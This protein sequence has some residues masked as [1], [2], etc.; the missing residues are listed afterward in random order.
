MANKL[1]LLVQFDS[2]GLSKLTGGIKGLVGA[3]KSGATA[4]RDMQ[5]DS[6][7]LKRE[8][9]A[10]GR[11]LR[12]ASGNVSHLVDREK[13][14]AQQLDRTNER[15]EK[16]K[17]LLAI[18]S[19]ANRWHARGDALQTR[20]RDN[21]IEGAAMAAP[22]FLAANAAMKNEKAMALMGQKLDLNRSETDALGRSLLRA[23]NDAKQLP[24]NI[25]AGA[26][27]LASKGL[28]RAEIEGMMPV[29]GRFA[30]AWDADVN[31]SAK[32][33]YANFLSLKVPLNQT[34]TALQIM[35]A[36]G[37]A[38]GF[39]VRD[40]AAEFPILASKMATLG[41]TG[42]PAVADLSAALQ[43]LE[44]KTGD[45][46]VAANALDNLMRFAGS[47]EG[48][49]KF[50][51]LG[52]DIPAA[53]K[54]AAAEGRS[55]IEELVRL[56]KQATGGDDSKLGLIFS[57][58]QA[59]IGITSL[60][61]GEKRYL[62]IR[63]EALAAT[64]LTDREFARMS[65][66]S[67]ANVQVLMGSLQGLTITLGTHLLPMLSSGAQWLTQTTTAVSV[68]AQANPGAASTLMSLAKWIVITKISLGALQFTFGGAMK[69]AASAWRVY[70][71]WKE[72]GTLARIFGIVK[73]AGMG[74]ARGL[75]VV[76]RAML[77][78]PVG[79][80]VTAIG[81]SAFL[82]WKHWDKI[83]LAF[84]AARGWLGT[85]WSWLKSN[86]LRMLEFAGPIGIAAKLV[87]THWDR[88]KGAFF[89][90]VA[91][92]SGFPARFKTIGVAIIDG[93]V[94]GIRAAPGKIWAAL[95]AIL[96]GA[97]KGAKAYL[98]INSPS[99]L[100]MQMG[101]FV[102][103]GLAIGIDRGQRRPVDSAR[104]LA[105]GV[106][107]GFRLPQSPF[108]A[109]SPTAAVPAA[110]GGG[111]KSGGLTISGPITMQIHQQPGENG[112]Q[113][114]QRIMRE[115]QRLSAKRARGSY[116]DR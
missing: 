52:I 63:K 69:T 38:G 95:K 10:T 49:K 70:A 51:K 35:A 64:G 29:I 7:R 75:L 24:D 39:E 58:A 67:S 54:K 18:D 21:V 46:A 89:S 103:D 20:G 104:R 65:K 15:I 112:E 26:D 25:I 1:S 109:G 13:E 30:T 66:T 16:Q 34:S 5:R 33:A 84:S 78:N 61:Q 71:K 68:W 102:S 60:I 93:L 91:F 62:D 19:R 82:I 37:R 85:A 81:I 32:A 45:G 44:S 73:S 108:A 6:A 79:L 40:M 55:P 113:M 98:G 86:A 110:S 9:L 8:M 101:G 114:G 76:G 80:L 83:K 27:F 36:A 31:D 106:A 57:D 59:L 2:P 42:L 77:L 100:F 12:S 23:A 107:G 90:A 56:T 14:L 47:A 96:S 48:I 87:I 11:E 17:R 111:A 105:Q 116:E 94:S 72:L 53:L 3:S 4:L 97:W 41:S 28:G 92:V 88:I 22:L 99:R 115:L 74:L 50:K 43:V